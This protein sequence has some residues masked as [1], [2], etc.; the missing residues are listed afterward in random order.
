MAVAFVAL[1]VALGGTA[2]ALNGKNTIDSNDVKKNAI[3]SANIAKNQVKGDDVNE[4]TL[5]EVP[6]A[7][8]GVQGYA[9]IDGAAGGT[10]DPVAPSLNVTSAN[11]SQGTSPGVYC[12]NGLAFTPRSILVTGDAVGGN[13]AQDN[14]TV[15]T[16]QD[17][18]ACP[19]VEQASVESR[20]D[21]DAAPA[22]LQVADFYI[23]FL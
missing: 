5:K 9:L 7:D 23:A 1:L 17:N 11:V 14:F 3:D 19:G 6:S 12:F 20:D 2:S 15:A 10:V 16:T 4:S 18:T 13:N 22:A 8:N 21:D